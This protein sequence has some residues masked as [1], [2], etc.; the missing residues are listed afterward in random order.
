V[1]ALWQYIKRNKLQDPDEREYVNNDKYLK[2]VFGIERMKFCEIPQRL[3][4]HLQQPDPIVINYAIDP[5]KMNVKKPT[6]YDIQIELDDGVRDLMSSFLNST[7]SQQELTAL[8]GKIHETV[9][10]INQLK[11]H[12]D[13]FLSFAVNPLKFMKDWL[14]SQT[15][16]LKVMTDT[17][18]NTEEERRSKF[19]DQ[20]WTHEAVHRYFY[21]QVQSKR[22]EL[23]QALGIKTPATAAVS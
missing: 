22:A 14:E 15:T 8:E 19:Y 6:C 10:G 20:V 3:Q 12:R 21:R 9:E 17:V 5:A 11:V 2:E 16:D 23:E 7:N 18:G 4:A 13:F 1:A